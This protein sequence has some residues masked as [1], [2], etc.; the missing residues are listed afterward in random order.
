MGKGDE[1]RHTILAQALD[2]AS[3]VGLEGL[4]LGVLAGR[5]GMSKSGL[6]AHF[7]SK[8][9]LQCQVLDT[10]AER[11]VDVVL[12]PA[13]KQPRG[14][15]RLETLF[16]LWLDWETDALSG[17]CPFIAAATELD[18]RPGPVRD[19]LTAH[20]HDV[21]GAVAR[22]ARIGVEEGHFRADLDVEQF[23]YELWGA[24]VA[25]QHFG[26]LLG[27]SDAGERAR[28]AFATLVERA[29][30]PGAATG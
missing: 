21:L 23:A 25:Y 14:L 6:Y 12:A 18:D 22:A 26:R 13:L 8:E 28:R 2:L 17:G 19:R 15:P 27:R 1:T 3:E 20:L 7:E 11:F 16:E 10:A 9:A 30:A 29:E 5:T 4:T 24:L